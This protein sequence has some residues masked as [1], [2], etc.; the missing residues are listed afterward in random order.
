MND[1]E[2]AE[3]L[4]RVAN[5]ELLKFTAEERKALVALK[6]QAGLT[7][8]QAEAAVAAQEQSDAQ[9]PEFVAA[10]KAA[11]KKAAA[12][13]AKKAAEE[14]A[15]AEEAAAEEAAKAKGKKK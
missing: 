5:G 10:K 11:E 15:A 8:A 7:P 3:F 14:E 9:R 6:R 2:I 12:E 1:E 13:A 4:G